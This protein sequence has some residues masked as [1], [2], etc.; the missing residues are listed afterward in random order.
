[1]ITDHY[2]VA[3]QLYQ[4]MNAGAIL[5]Y[6]RKQ[7]FHQCGSVKLYMDYGPFGMILLW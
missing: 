5:A 7:P 2:T 3:Y 1:M 6:H 4:F